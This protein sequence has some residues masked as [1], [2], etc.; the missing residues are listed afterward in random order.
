MPEFVHQE[1][2]EQRHRERHPREQRPR[3]VGPDPGDEL[4]ER[5]DRAAEAGVGNRS[6]RPGEDRPGVAQ[7]PIST[8][9]P[10]WEPVWKFYAKFE[11]IIPEDYTGLLGIRLHRTGHPLTLEFFGPEIP[12]KT[13]YPI[14]VLELRNGDL[15]RSKE[16][17]ETEF[18]APWVFAITLAVVGA[19][20]V[21]SYVFQNREGDEALGLTSEIAAILVF[22]LG[23][24]AVTG[25]VELAG[26]LGVATSAVLAFKRPLHHLVERIG[27]D[28]LYAGIKLLIAS[29]VVL[30]L[31]P[32]APVDP[33]GAINPY[34]LWLLVILISALSMVGYVAVRWLGTAH[35][36]A[37]TGIA[38]ALVSSTA[39][40]LSLA[41]TSRVQSDPVHAR[42]LVAAILLAWF[43]M[44]V[45]VA[46]VLAERREAGGDRE[47]AEAEVRP[48]PAE[49]LGERLAV[50]GLVDERL[51]ERQVER[52]VHPVLRRGARPFH[53][54]ALHRA[55]Q[56]DGD[57]GRGSGQREV[58]HRPAAACGGGVPEAGVRLPERAGGGDDVHRARVDPW[59]GGSN[60]PQDDDV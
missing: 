53:D 18:D 58:R 29:F 2:R 12:N 7:M 21:S 38:G 36:N 9:I 5:E 45:R 32:D 22:L 31:L 16:K 30:P 48:R 43:V 19:G 27:F 25:N 8:Y 28:D 6:P 11:S 37:I 24:M 42:A 3:R 4:E 39:A 46:V 60:R 49:R 10:Q 15:V 55:D 50:L 40:T 14:L 54:H 59:G 44:F 1:N 17:I 33:W 47:I 57:E 35:G 13:L 26:A 34:K 41:R 20:V 23:A 51:E 56:Q 52:D